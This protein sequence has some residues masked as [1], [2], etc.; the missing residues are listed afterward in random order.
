M[1]YELHESEGCAPIKLWTRGVPVEGEALRQLENVARLPIIHKWV[2]AM[3][4]VHWGYGATVGSVIPTVGAIIPAA[5]GVDIGCFVGETKVPL[6][7]G[8]QC[9]ME[10]LESETEPFWIYSIDSEGEI[11]PGRARCVRTRSNAELVKIVVSGGDEIVCTPDQ[12]FML[13]DGNYREAKDLG[14]GHNHKVI[15]TEPL[16]RRADVYCLQV[17]DH[18][19]FA[20]SAG[21]FVHNCGMVAARTTLAASDLP[22]N[23]AP[24]RDAIEQAVPHGRSG[25]GGRGAKGSWGDYIPPSTSVLWDLL[26]PGFKRIVDKHP[27]IGGCNTVVHLGT[28]GTGN[29]FIEVCLD[30]SD[31][32]WFMLHSGSRGVGARIGGYFIQL[33]RADME[34]H[35]ANLPDADLAYFTEGAEHFNDYVEAV[36]WAQEFARTNRKIMLNSVIDAAHGVA[37]VRP[38]HVDYAVAN[39]FRGDT[40]FIT[41]TGVRTLAECAGATIRVLTSTG[42]WVDAHVRSFGEQ[43]LMRLTLGRY[44][45]TKTI[46]VT[47]EHRWFVDPLQRD[48]VAKLTSE[49]EPGDRLAFQ[50]ARQA[51]DGFDPLFE[52]RGFVF[53]DGSTRSANTSCAN[54]CGPKISLLDRFRRLAGNVPRNYGDTTRITGLPGHWKMKTCDLFDAKPNEIAGWLA[55]YFAA[56]GDIDKTGRPTITSSR[57]DHLELY[58]DLCWLIGIAT[59]PIRVSFRIGY[60]EEESPLYLMGI[61]RNDLPED[62]FLRDDHRARLRHVHERL[63]WKVLAAEATALIDEV[64]CTQVDETH[65]FVLEDG[66][67][68]SNCHH[69]FVSREHHYGQDVFVT[70]KGAV[71]ARAGELGII[72]GSM[73]ARSYIVRGKGHPESFHSCSHGA[74]RVMSRTKAKKVF[75]VED[76]ALATAGVECRKDEGVIDET[77]GAYKDIDAVMAAQEDLV[78]VVHTLK[79]VVCVKG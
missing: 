71:S 50:R 63:N 62:F 22:D 33:A 36:G 15:A 19:N 9:S 4:D 44:D 64:F 68:T 32:V 1:N 77:P 58:R 78:E 16:S 61:S 47:A 57:R 72:P 11:A 5:V 55:G 53:G 49:L 43:R 66:V 69:N 37:G 26:E 30:E 12:H 34:H 17:E 54:F 14:H 51:F 67:L 10:D 45:L 70:R 42:E 24:M 59:Y 3:P 76:H 74:G 41:A 29:H 35:I 65:S 27:K 52:Y 73:G 39:C 28:L 60:G 18:H 25:H 31:R 38:F 8:R 21:V 46:Y 56:D 23:L 40:R 13:K 79:Q 20:L 48:R 6:L 75:T 7:N 2:A